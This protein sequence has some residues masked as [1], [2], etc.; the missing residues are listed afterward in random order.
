MSKKGRVTD[1][2]FAVRAVGGLFM[3]MKYKLSM[4][5]DNININDNVLHTSH[6]D[7]CA[8]GRLVSL[9][10]RV[11]RWDRTAAARGQDPPW[12]AAREQLWVCACEA[13]RRY[14]EPRVQGGVWL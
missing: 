3:N 2:D 11:P 13:P 5:R 7:G 6:V 1:V 14:R 9:D 12:P 4:L 10:V 8:Q